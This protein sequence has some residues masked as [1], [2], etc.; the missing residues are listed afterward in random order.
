[1]WKNPDKSLPDEGRRCWGS[2]GVVVTICGLLCLAVALVFCQTGRYDFVNFD[3]DQYVYDADHLK[4]GFTWDGV[5]YYLYHW[6]SYTY[7]PLATFSHMLDCQLF[8]LRAGGHHAMNAALHAVT[9]V[10]LFLLLRQLTGRLWPSALVAA[11]FAVHPLRVE[12]VAWISERKD[13]L[14]GLFFVLTLGAYARYVRAPAARGRYATVCALYA[15]GLL[16]KPMLVTLPGVLL[17]LDYWPLRRLQGIT[18]E[19][20]ILKP[21]R[22]ASE[23]SSLTLRVSADQVCCRSNIEDGGGGLKPTLLDEDAWRIPWHLLTEKIPLMLFAVTVSGLT[24]H[25]QV[26]AIRSLESVSW[27]ARISNTL[28]AYVSYLGCFFWPHGLAI[29]YP[30]PGDGHSAWTIAT[31]AAVLAA[32]S[33][34]AF[35]LRR[36]APYLLVGWL[37]Y[38]GMLVPVIGLLQV[39]GQALADRYTYLPQIGFV[40]GLVWALADLVKFCAARAGEAMRRASFAL[41]ALAA[42]GVVAA[43]AV[44][45]WRQT[46]YWRDSETVWARD[47]MY[48]TNVGHFNFGLA[49]AAENRHEEALKQFEQ[50][51]VISPEDEDTLYSYGQSLQALG[52]DAEA[53]AKYRATLAVNKRSA[54]ANDGLA[55]VLLKQGKDRDALECWRLAVAEEPKNVAYGCRLA[56]LLAASSDARVRDGKEAVAIAEKMVEL[57]RGKDASAFNA[58]AAAEAETGNF[59]AAVENAQ[60]ALDLAKADG[61][62]KLAGEVQSR[63]ADYRAGKPYRRKPGGETLGR[64]CR[65]LPAARG[66]DLQSLPPE[67]VRRIIAKERKNP[68]E[69]LETTG[70]HTLL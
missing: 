21:T 22:S 43:F 23:D 12:S 49:L 14:S 17:L 34:G 50:A 1:M 24:I 33:A 31:A 19:R 51:R 47:E 45:A 9:A 60:T 48:P 10:L 3:D 40:L 65:T 69:G 67:F 37:W 61:E 13:V 70:G 58:L 42:A 16:A 4:H 46:G 41:L 38:L 15:L 64:P 66:V 57:S 27:W 5:L 36:R 54:R 25:T 26:E 32:I 30:H 52:R 53:M 55:A 44:A 18:A 8:G 35:V 7:H 56:E 28:V 59:S 39:G 6:H 11:L 2:R 63:L 20:K 62:E 29:L 68:R